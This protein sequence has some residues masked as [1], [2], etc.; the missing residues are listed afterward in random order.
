MVKITN[1]NPEKGF[2]FLVVDGKRVFVH[3]LVINP[4]PARGVDLTGQE[5]VVEEVEWKAEKGPRA[6]SVITAAEH[7]RRET[8][9]E[10]LFDKRL[11]DLVDAGLKVFSRLDRYATAADFAAA[12]AQIARIG[13]EEVKVGGEFEIYADKWVFLVGWSEEK[14][15]LA[16]ELAER[17]G[18][19]PFVS[20]EEFPRLVVTSKPEDGIHYHPLAKGSPSFGTI[21]G[22]MV[23]TKVAEVEADAAFV[24]AVAERDALKCQFKSHLAVKPADPS[25]LEIETPEGWFAAAEVEYASGNGRRFG[26]WVRRGD[27]PRAPAPGRQMIVCRY[28]NP[29]KLDL[30]LEATEMM[31]GSTYYVDTPESI[32]WLQECQQLKEAY[33]AS[34][35]AVWQTASDLFPE[36]WATALLESHGIDARYAVRAEDVMRKGILSA[37]RPLE[38]SRALNDWRKPRKIWWPDEWWVTSAIWQVEGSQIVGFPTNL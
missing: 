24:K 32:A 1:W 7:K 27:V 21:L 6:I 13:Q 38:L 19:F 14:E 35:E 31:E 28:P 8:D 20:V 25:P 22:Q 15:V 26:G 33:K 12:L 3:C 36:G 18:G 9:P 16:L 4:R 5:V 11:Q 23:E 10:T 30:G 34:H 37:V 2:G 17:L 29:R